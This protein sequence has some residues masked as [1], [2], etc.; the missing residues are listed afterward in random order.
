MKRSEKLHNIASN[1]EDNFIPNK[2]FDALI[3]KERNDSWKYDGKTVFGDVRPPRR[4]KGVQL[5]LF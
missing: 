2:I 3:Q 1:A 4:M 5:K